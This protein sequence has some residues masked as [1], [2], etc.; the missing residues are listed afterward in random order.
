MPD[1]ILC[2]TEPTLRLPLLLALTPICALAGA[3][4]RG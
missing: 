3:A 4:G 2:S 1:Y